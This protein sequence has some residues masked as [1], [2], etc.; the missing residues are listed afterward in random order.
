MGLVTKWLNHLEKL[1]LP[2]PSNFDFSF[3]LKGISIALE[4]EHSISTPKSLNLI[5]RTLHYFPIE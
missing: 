3:F 4:I 2:F 1:C 5:Y